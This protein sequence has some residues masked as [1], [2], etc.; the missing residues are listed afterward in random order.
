VKLLSVNVGRPRPVDWNDTVIFTSIWKASVSG[1]VRVRALNLEGDEQ[2]DLS[3]HGGAD[4]AVYAYPAEHYPDWRSD[5]DHPDLAWAS[6]GENL[7]TR[8]LLETDV[9]IGDRMRIGSSE[10]V[11]TQPRLPCFK[12]ALRLG[13]ED[14][15][16]RF[17]VR[18]RSG[19]YL[20]VLK[21]G[22][23]EAGNAIEFVARADGNP[24]VAEMSALRNGLVDDP[25]LLRRALASRAL[26]PG[27]REHFRRRLEDG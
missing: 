12:L 17:V 1:S 14:I 26:T 20:R 10:F 15:I 9:R 19:F 3:V 4:K 8:G 22:V 13:R 7:T 11:V 23:V 6:F 18:N 5:L 2:S 16:R 24:T 27:W 21:E 25:D